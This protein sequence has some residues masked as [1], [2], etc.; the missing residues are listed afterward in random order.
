MGNSLPILCIAIPPNICR[1]GSTGCDYGGVRRGV[2][3]VGHKWG[4]FGGAGSESR[5]VG[6]DPDENC[7]TLTRTGGLGTQLQP[8][9]GS[10]WKLR[11][12]RFSAAHMTASLLLLVP[13]CASAAAGNL[14][15][16]PSH[17]TH[18]LAEYSDSTPG[19]FHGR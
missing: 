15:E 12:E 3:K 10:K 6:G 9:L 4:N 1:W 13:D 14:G 7:F 18:H 19:T 17:E 16:A 11:L 5:T 2:A 8:F